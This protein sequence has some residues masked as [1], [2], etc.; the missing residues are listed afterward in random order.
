MIAILQNC[1]GKRKICS[2]DSMKT[3]EY[4]LGET[5]EKWFSDSYKRT[6]YLVNKTL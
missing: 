5:I 1:R 4:S 6:N 3:K 2:F